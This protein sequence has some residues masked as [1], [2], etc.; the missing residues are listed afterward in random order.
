MGLVGWNVLWTSFIERSATSALLTSFLFITSN[1]ISMFFTTNQFPSDHNERL[2][3]PVVSM[4]GTR[5]SAVAER[6]RDALSHCNFAKSLKIIGN[7]KLDRSHTSSY[8]PSTVIMALYCIISE[9]KRNTCQPPPPAFDSC[10]RG[11]PSEYCHNV[12]YGKTRM[13]W[14]TDGEKVWRYV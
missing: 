14:L 2:K 12:W 10:V 5:N 3:F 13:V 11:C 1:V 9:I 4:L 7:S 8:W 6:P